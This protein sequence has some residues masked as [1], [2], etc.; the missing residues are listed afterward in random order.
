MSPVGFP[1]FEGLTRRRTTRAPVNPMDKSTIVSIYPKELDEVKHTIMPSRFHLDAGSFENPAIL[2]VGSSSWWREVDEESPL[3]EIPNSSIQVADSIVKDYC[4][5]L[6][7]CNMVD[8]MPGIFYIPGEFTKIELKIKHKSTLEKAKANQERWF[9]ALVKM[10]DTLWAKTNGNPI[11]ISDDMRMAA[12]NLNLTEKDW[13]KDFT[14]IE[15]VRCVACG[16]PRNPGFPVCPNCHAIVD[17]EKAKSLNIK[18]A[19]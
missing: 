8:A 7:A 18:F 1:G 11:T 15:N 6:L 19:E 17:T 12:K 4:N 9:Q 10:A 2:V 3:L 13:M 5:G 16:T 14:M